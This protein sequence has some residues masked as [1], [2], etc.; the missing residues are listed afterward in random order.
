M[1]TINPSTSYGLNLTIPIYTGFQTR[2]QRAM[3]RAVYQ[4]SVLTSHVYNANGLPGPFINLYKLK[5]GDQIIV[6]AYG[7]K[8]VFEVQTNQ[9]VMPN[10][11]S[12]FKHEEKPWMTLITCKGYDEKSNTYKMRVVVRAVLVKV[13]WDK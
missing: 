7:Q 3:A 6:R 10:D 2:A 4:N 1:R 5:Y 12:A 9:V 11:R 13:L 8:Y